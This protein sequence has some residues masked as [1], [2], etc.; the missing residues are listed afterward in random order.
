MIMVMIMVMDD[1]HVVLSI[2]CGFPIFSMGIFASSAKAGIARPSETTVASA[3]TNLF[4]DILPGHRTT[5][6][7][8]YGK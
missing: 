8:I 2:I 4:M 5:I 3:T 1:H 7:N 6:K